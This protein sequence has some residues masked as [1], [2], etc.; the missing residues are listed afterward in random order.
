MRLA[1]KEKNLG[2][3]LINLYWVVQISSVHSFPVWLRNRLLSAGLEWVLS[4]T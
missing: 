4:Q 3:F 1:N 2:D